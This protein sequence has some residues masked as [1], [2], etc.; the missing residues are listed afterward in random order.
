M[1]LRA[2]TSVSLSPVPQQ[3]RPR[4]SSASIPYRSPQTTDR[5]RTRPPLPESVEKNILYVYIHAIR[6]N[7][8]LIS[9]IGAFLD[10]YHD[11]YPDYETKRRVAKLPSDWD[12]S[13]ATR[14]APPDFE[15]KEGAEF[16]QQLK[17]RKWS[18]SKHRHTSDTEDSGFDHNSPPSLPEISSKKTN[19]KTKQSSYPPHKARQF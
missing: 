4:W 10:K 13:T 9:S 8:P 17:Y 5:Q 19:S 1:M 7:P 11:L 14:E 16:V 6:S 15:A 2:S 12:Q 18:E 3:S